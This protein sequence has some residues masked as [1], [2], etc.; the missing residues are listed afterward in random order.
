MQGSRL[1]FLNIQVGD[2]DRRENPTPQQSIFIE[3]LL[4]TS[5]P[6]LSR[7]YPS[8]NPNVFLKGCVEVLSH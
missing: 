7:M 8:Y 5:T 6:T 4:F 3:H 2:F 1:V